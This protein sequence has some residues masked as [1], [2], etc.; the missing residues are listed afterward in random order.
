MNKKIIELLDSL[1]TINMD[2]I[3]NMTS[4]SKQ[5]FLND[6]IKKVCCHK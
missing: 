2:G 1:N 5:K 3:T 6:T 4:I